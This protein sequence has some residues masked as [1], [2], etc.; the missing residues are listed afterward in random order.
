LVKVAVPLVGLLA[1]L[2]RHPLLHHHHHLLH[3]LEI[4]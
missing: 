2:Y 3:R 4:I 1:L